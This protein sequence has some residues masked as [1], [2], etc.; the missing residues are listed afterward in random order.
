M[1]S[2]RD[3]EPAEDDDGGGPDDLEPPPEIDDAEL[4]DDPFAQAGDVPAGIDAGNEPW[5]DS[6]R[7]Y[8]YQEVRRHTH[9]RDRVLT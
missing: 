9:T 1:S 2:K 6:D 4:G 5:L 3:K 7:D 8:T